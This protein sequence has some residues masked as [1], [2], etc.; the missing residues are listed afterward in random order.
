MNKE[1]KNRLLFLN[2]FKKNHPAEEILD[3]ISRIKDLDILAIGE[4]IIDEYQYGFTLGKSGKSPIIAF[5][6]EGNERYDGGVLAIRN[7]LKEFVHKVDYYTDKTMMVKKRYTQDGQKLFETYDI[8]KNK[9]KGSYGDIGRYDIVIIADFGH[10]FLTK[11]RRNTI[12]NQSKFIA[13]NAQANAGN[14]GLNTINKYSRWD[15]ISIDEHELR[16]ATSNQFDNIR[17]ILLDRFDKG[18]VTITKGS[19]GCIVFNNRKI[20]DIPF[21]KTSEKI[22]DSIGAGDALFSISSLI[23]YQNAPPEVI[24]FIGNLA[25]N[26]ACSYPG[27]KYHVTKDKLLNNIKNIYD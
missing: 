10:G 18:I 19:K 26:I 11:E 9:Y 16:L 7:H 27:N 15:Y 5:Q 12:E 3:Y 4:T 6:N 13:L 24:G 20:E 25:G 21:L 22:V 14:M 17:D 8:K 23:A 1:E 2:N